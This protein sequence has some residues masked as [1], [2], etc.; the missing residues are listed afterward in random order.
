IASKGDANR[1]DCETFTWSDPVN[2][3]PAV[4]SA[5]FDSAATLSPNGLSLFFVS[6]RPHPGEPGGATDIWVSQR[7]CANCPWRHA[8]SLTAINTAADEGAPSLSSDG[9]LL[10]FHSNR[11]DETAQGGSDIWVAYRDDPNDDF[12][13][14]TPLNLGPG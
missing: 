10:F 12:H 11:P 13:W 3:G 6:N 14:H 9:R 1:P 7:D 5:S 4:N 2:L 8:V